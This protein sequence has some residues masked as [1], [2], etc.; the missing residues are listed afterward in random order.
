MAISEIR[1]KQ[2][3]EFCEHLRVERGFSSHTRRAYLRTLERFAAHLTD[4]ERTFVDATNIDIR[5]FLALVGRGRAP[6]TL[7]RHVAALRTFYKWLHRKGLVPASVVEHLRPPKTDSKLPDVLSEAQ[8]RTVLE[9]PDHSPME[10]AMLE[11]MYASGLRVG[12]ITALDRQDLDL[13]QGLV[14]VRRGKGGKP[15]VVPMGSVA[16][17]AVS[18]WLE[19]RTDQREAVFLAVRGGRMSARGARSLVEQAGRRAGVLGLHPHTLRHSCATHMLD[20][21]ADLRG[22]Q[23][24]L[25]HR[26]LSTTQRY[27]H[28]SVS[29][30]REVYRASHP[31]A[32]GARSRRPLN[33]SSRRRDEDEEEG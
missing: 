26:S 33:E 25:G 1:Q 9:H 28:L 20:S 16:R 24:L 10:R 7:A 6:A 4:Q 12:E 22:I 21:G 2:V 11:I 29:R 32:K 19:S 15:R 18:S 23:E 17:E 30:L 27:T 31:H 13:S 8:T 14:H 3:E 5:S